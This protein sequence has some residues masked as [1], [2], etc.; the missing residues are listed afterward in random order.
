M[1]ITDHTHLDTFKVSGSW[2]PGMTVRLYN[3]LIREGIDTVGKVRALQPQD[4][5][6]FRN[7]G[8]MGYEEG[9]E[10]QRWLEDNVVLMTDEQAMDQLESIWNSA[11]TADGWNGGD[12]VDTIGDLLRLTGRKAP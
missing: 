3:V 9:R 1:K 11:E 2:G 4:L 7:I 6:A 12:A 8:A 10:L 5:F